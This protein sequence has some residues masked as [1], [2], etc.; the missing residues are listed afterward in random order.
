[1]SQDEKAKVDLIE[2][3]VLRAIGVEY[4]AKEIEELKKTHRKVYDTYNG[5]TKMI[6]SGTAMLPRAVAKKLQDAGAVKIVL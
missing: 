2:V 3:E 1:M 4:T 5:L 6:H